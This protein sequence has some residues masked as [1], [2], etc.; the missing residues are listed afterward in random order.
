V[1]GF[2]EYIE[3]FWRR[4]KISKTVGTLQDYFQYLIIAARLSIWHTYI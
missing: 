2:S 4:T 3:T 1:R